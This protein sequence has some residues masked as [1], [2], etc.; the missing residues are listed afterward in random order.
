MSAVEYFLST[1]DSMATTDIHC[2]RFMSEAGL[3][4]HYFQQLN[5]EDEI[6]PAEIVLKKIL[7]RKRFAIF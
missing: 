7:T 1:S 4:E 3:A 5:S 6:Y 2:L